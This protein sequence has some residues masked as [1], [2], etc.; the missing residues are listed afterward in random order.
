[1][2]NVH[3]NVDLNTTTNLASRDTHSTDDTFNDDANDMDTGRHYSTLNDYILFLGVTWTA[4]S[5][6]YDW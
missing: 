3:T 6:N 1:M 5:V 4:T 2:K